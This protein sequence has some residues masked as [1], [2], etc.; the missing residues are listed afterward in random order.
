MKLQ[1]VR[2][3]G[4]LLCGFSEQGRG[5]VHSSGE[6]LGHCSPLGGTAAWEFSLGFRL[7]LLEI[8]AKQS[9]CE[10][11]GERAAVLC[12]VS[13]GRGYSHVN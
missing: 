10:N 13:Q 12:L 6:L 5:H 11:L 2:A 8:T 4:I 3:A 9:K 1:H 7:G